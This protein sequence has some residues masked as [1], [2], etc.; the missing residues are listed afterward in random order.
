MQEGGGGRMDHDDED[1]GRDPVVASIP[2]KFSQAL[3]KKLYMMQ[4]PMRPKRRPYSD[5]MRCGAVNIKPGQAKV[6][7]VYEINMLGDNYDVENPAHIESFKLSSTRIRN[8]ANYALGVVSDGALHLNPVTNVLRMKPDLT[9][10]DDA[11]KKRKAAEDEEKRRMLGLPKEKPKQVTRQSQRRAPPSHSKARQQMKIRELMRNV[12]AEEWRELGYYPPHSEESLAERARM[13]NTSSSSSSPET[14]SQAAFPIS[15]IQYLDRTMQLC[16]TKPTA[17]RGGMKAA[18]R[19][20]G[21][22]E[23]EKGEES[24]DEKVAEMEL[25]GTGRERQHA[26]RNKD[27]SI[28]VEKLMRQA[29]VASFK[30]ICQQVGAKTARDVDIALQELKRNSLMVQGNWVERSGLTLKN[31]QAHAR[32]YLLA[33]FDRTRRLERKQLIPVLK[34]DYET[35]TKLLSELGRPLGDGYWEFRKPTDTEF[36]KRY[37]TL[38]SKQARSVSKKYAFSLKLLLE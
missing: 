11:E 19:N 29:K 23:G 35:T 10:L 12:E 31:R 6:Q 8:K 30:E 21:D 20:K 1:D 28:R 24:G 9:Y 18:L 15:K 5:D 37:P 4:F 27:L 14:L 25:D 16:S 33:S 13:N 3:A 2:V 7:M 34:L 22:G 26:D 36:M 32:N 17:Q 38:T